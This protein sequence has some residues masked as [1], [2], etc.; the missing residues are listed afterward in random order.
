MLHHTGFLNAAPPLTFV[1]TWNTNNAG[2]S[3]ANQITLPLTASTSFPVSVDWGD[4]NT[5]VITSSTDPNLTH[6]FATPGAQTVTVNGFVNGW[7]FNNGGDAQKL[8]DVTDWGGFT[9]WL[10]E[11]RLFGARR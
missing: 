4:G 8:T 11:C 3:A 5:D 6:T 7:S 1:S 10:F 2:T 9:A